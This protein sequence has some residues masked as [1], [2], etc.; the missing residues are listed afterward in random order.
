MAKSSEWKSKV[1]VPRPFNDL[2]TRNVLVMDFIPGDKVIRTVME[3][4][5]KIAASQ[6]KSLAELEAEFES[7][8]GDNSGEQEPSEWQL[9]VMRAF[10]RTRDFTWNML[11]LTLNFTVGPVFWAL[12]HSSYNIVPC[13]H[14]ELPLNT[15]ALSHSVVDV[16]GYQMFIDG[17]FNADPHAGNILYMPNGKLGLIDYGQVKRLSIEDRRILANLIVALDERNSEDI[18]KSMDEIGFTTKNQDPYVA[19]KLA[20]TFLDRDD[21]EATDG[22]PLEIFF[23]EMD[24]RD[25]ITHMPDILVMAITTAFIVR[26]V[27]LGLGHRV[28]TAQRWRK[29]AD[30]FLAENSEIDED[31]HQA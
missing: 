25:P 9:Q 7:S 22:I 23:E 8:G 5:E 20:V 24:R 12:G 15:V 29:Y 31:R 16:H 2:C 6:G 14:T 1:V 27:S 10:F 4:W 21:L 19:E 26:G 17:V 28:S 30:R 13:K 18:V 11:A 3:R